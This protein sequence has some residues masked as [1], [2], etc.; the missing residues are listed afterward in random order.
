MKQILRNELNKI[1]E[2]ERKG[3]RLIDSQKTLL[4][5]FNDFKTIFNNNNDNNN[6]ESNSKNV[7]ES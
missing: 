1:K 5:L 4:S 6:N 3:R 2:V 7:N